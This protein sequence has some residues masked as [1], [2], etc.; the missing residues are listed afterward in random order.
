[1]NEPAAVLQLK[2]SYDVRTGLLVLAAIVVAFLFSIALFASFIQPVQPPHVYFAAGLV[3]DF[4][5][6]S[7]TQFKSQHLILVRQQNGEFVA[8]YDINPRSPNYT[9]IGD[10]RYA[11][12]WSGDYG[13]DLVPGLE[14]R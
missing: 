2:R 7:V 9:P 4:A 11:K 10:C 1:M 6:A 13:Q 5:S 14:N 8:L 12:L 3:D